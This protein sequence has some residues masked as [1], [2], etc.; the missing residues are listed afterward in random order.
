M[1][2]TNLAGPELHQYLTYL[3][4]QAFVGA[5][6]SEELADCECLLRAIAEDRLDSELLQPPGKHCYFRDCWACST[7]AS[8]QARADTSEAAFPVKRRP[9]Y[10]LQGVLFLRPDL[11]FPQ[12]SA[13]AS[14]LHGLQP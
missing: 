3:S 5:A 11:P 10:A 4:E 2:A 1:Q 7:Q 13:K 12:A 8:P 14:E 9:M 6:V